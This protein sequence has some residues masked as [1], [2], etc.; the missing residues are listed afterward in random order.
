MAGRLGA[1]LGMLAARSNAAFRPIGAL[2]G[3]KRAGED[4]AG[5]GAPEI[6]LK[7]WGRFTE[8]ARRKKSA[9]EI[10]S[11]LVQVRRIRA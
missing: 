6:P 5:R 10:I 9:P 4:G 3:L 7:N 1:S 2:E 8:R 11:F